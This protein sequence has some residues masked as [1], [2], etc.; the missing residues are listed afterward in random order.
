MKINELLP[1]KVRYSPL[2]TSNGKGHGKPVQ[3]NRLEN[4]VVMP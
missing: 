1:L 4:E 3:V 2:H